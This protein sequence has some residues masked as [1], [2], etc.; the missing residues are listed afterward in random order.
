MGNAIVAEFEPEMDGRTRFHRFRYHLAR[1]YVVPT[2]HVLDL[3]CGTGYGSNILSQVAE[4]V[5]GYDM[6]QSNIDA[7]SQK[8]SSINTVFK[9]ENLEQLELP[10]CDVAV[11][12]EVLEHLYKPAE[13]VKKL[14]QSVS[15]YIIMSI[16]VGC[17]KLIEVDGDI[18]A[19]LDSTHHSVFASGA[20]LVSLFSDQWG[21]FFELQLGVTFIVVL[22]K[23]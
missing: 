22:M 20:E 13:F 1:G 17:E 3:G 9:C 18:Q 11:M 6:E 7:C 2:D 12:F 21:V 10:P 19:D 5:I 23:K 16:P 15:K 8:Y 4:T 14:E